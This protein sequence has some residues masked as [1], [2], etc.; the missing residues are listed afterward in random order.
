MPIERHPP[1]TCSE[2]SR[3]HRPRAVTESRLVHGRITTGHGGTS[4]LNAVPLLVSPRLQPAS[5]ALRVGSVPHHTNIVEIARV[6]L[7]VHRPSIARTRS[8]LTKTPHHFSSPPIEVRE[9][10]V[11]LVLSNRDVKGARP[12]HERDDQQQATFRAPSPRLSRPGSIILLAPPMRRAP[13]SLEVSTRYS[14]DSH[15]RGPRLLLTPDDRTAQRKWLHVPTL[16]QNLTSSPIRRIRS[17]RS[18]ARVIPSPNIQ[19]VAPGVQS[20]LL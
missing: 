4:S 15:V 18:L 9:R 12:L 16:T 19:H 17:P 2:T 7:S 5:Q 8:A 3:L 11:Q 1:L 13:T 20:L 14:G 6:V 10:V